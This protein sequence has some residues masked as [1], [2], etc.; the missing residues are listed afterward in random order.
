[1]SI[2]FQ[3][4]QFS[5]WR[6]LSRKEGRQRPRAPSCRAAQQAAFRSGVTP[7]AQPQPSAPWGEKSHLGTSNHHTQ[8]KVPLPLGLQKG[9]GH[10]ARIFPEPPQPRWV[11]ANFAA[12]V[13]SLFFQKEQSYRQIQILW[14]LA[15]LVICEVFFPKLNACFVTLW[16]YRW[17]ISEGSTVSINNPRATK[18]NAHIS[19]GPFLLLGQGW[20]L[21]CAPQPS[22]A[23]RASLGL[24][25]GAHPTTQWFLFHMRLLIVKRNLPHFIVLMKCSF[26]ELLIQVTPDII[27]LWV[28]DRVVRSKGKDNWALIKKYTFC[29][30]LSCTA[31]ITLTGFS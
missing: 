27:K 18:T 6:S 9:W 28:K 5:L 13:C 8:H 20:S 10:L 2:A 15:N 23:T 12:R 17:N 30:L 16:I 3:E 26:I 4:K 14:H 19:K 24:N 25:K 1:M 31:N 7:P 22:R 21:G 29:T 11:S